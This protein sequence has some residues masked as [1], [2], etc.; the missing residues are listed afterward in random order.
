MIG[1]E[2]ARFH[3]AGKDYKQRLRHNP[4]GTGLDDGGTRHAGAIPTSMP[5]TAISSSMPACRITAQVISPK[6]PW[7]AIHADL[8]HDNALFD[9]GQLGGILDFDYACVDWF[10]FDHRRIDQ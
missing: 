1:S 6:L 4:R 10:V 7:G 5:R 8:F 2:L 9:E 3:L